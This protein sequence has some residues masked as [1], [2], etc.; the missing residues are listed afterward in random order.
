MYRLTDCILN[1]KLGLKFNNFP[2]KKLENK[3]I[4]A[5][6]KKEFDHLQ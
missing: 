2:V 1:E 6:C 3:D 5:A 4:Q